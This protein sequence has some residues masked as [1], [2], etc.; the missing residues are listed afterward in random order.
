MTNATD[1]ALADEI[2]RIDTSQ[3]EEF[4]DRLAQRLEDGTKRAQRFAL[5][6]LVAAAAL[7]LRMWEP[8]TA[9]SLRGQQISAIKSLNVLLFLSNAILYMMAALGFTHRVL[10]EAIIRVALTREGQSQLVMAYSYGAGNAADFDRLIYSRAV[11]VQDKRRLD[12]HQIVQLCFAIAALV[13]FVL[14]LLPPTVNA[15]YLARLS[16][17]GTAA[18]FLSVLGWLLVVGQL[19]AALG[20]CVYTRQ[21]RKDRSDDDAAKGVSGGASGE[22]GPGLPAEAPRA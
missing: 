17:S 18:V 14:I 7:A 4:F 19:A 3:Q 21:Y 6:S 15:I 8:D 5:L 12:S 16:P 10:T 2:A 11:S 20:L 1:S 9:L 13:L 22:A